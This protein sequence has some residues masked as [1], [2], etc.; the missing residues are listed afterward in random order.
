MAQNEN[1]GEPLMKLSN[2]I[3]NL[4]NNGVY[5]IYSVAGIA[6]AEYLLVTENRKTFLLT[7]D[8]TFVGEGPSFESAKLGH[9]VTFPGIPKNNSFRANAI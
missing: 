4:V 6:G 9:P 5:S 3:K 1:K 7:G 8:G 2:D